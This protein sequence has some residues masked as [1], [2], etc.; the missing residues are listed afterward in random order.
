MPYHLTELARLRP[1]DS[2]ALP[3]WRTGTRKDERRVGLEV[4]RVAN[5]RQVLKKEWLAGD[6]E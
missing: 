4:D 1:K 6:P 5:S 2:V 3:Y